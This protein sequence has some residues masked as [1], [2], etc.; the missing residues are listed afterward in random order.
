VVTEDLPI[1]IKEL[2]QLPNTKER[3]KEIV[4]TKAKITEE[5]KL[6]TMVETMTKTIVNIIKS[7]ATLWKNVGHSKPRNHQCM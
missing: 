1:T 2:H 6:K 4:V 7:Q 5:A 3:T